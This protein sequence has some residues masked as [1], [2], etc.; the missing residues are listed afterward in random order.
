MKQLIRHNYVATV[1]AAGLILPAISFAG[2]E[3]DL[4]VGI[5]AFNRGDLITAMGNYR[6]AADA[7]LAEAQVRLAYILDYSEDNDEALGLYRAAA[8]Q[9]NSD[10]QFGL[11]EMYAKGEGTEQDYEKAV[12]QF[13]RAADNDN[14]RAIWL[15]FRAYE[16][17]E[18]GLQADPALAGKWLI[19]GAEIGDRTAMQELIAAYEEGTHGLQANPERVR[20]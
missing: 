12:E 20:R 1:L 14:L 11:G 4:Q 2:P 13:T 18:L 17:G 8:D 9:G 7:G 5:D 6:K 10:G 19:R 3:E 15:L 16:T